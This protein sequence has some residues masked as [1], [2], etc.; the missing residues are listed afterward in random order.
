[1]T[2]EM[3]VS[4]QFRGN[5]A[6]GGNILNSCFDSWPIDPCL[7]MYTTVHLAN[8]LPV[9]MYTQAHRVGTHKN[10]LKTLTNSHIKHFKISTKTLPKQK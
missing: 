3:L 5:K 10:I 9:R 8:K 1:M 2:Y 6:S 4:A 7:Y